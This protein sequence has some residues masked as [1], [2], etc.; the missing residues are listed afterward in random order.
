MSVNEKAPVFVVGCPRSGTTLLYDTLLSSG[1]FAVYPC[2]SDVF[3]RIAPAFGSFRSKSTRQKLMDV[4]L[5]SDYFGRT[6]LEPDVLRSR[7]L[8]D[9]RSAGDFLRITMESIARQQ[10][11]GRWADN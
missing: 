9:C 8:T 7:V 3:Y 10:G 2:E 1:K 4:W 5:A 11:V 6:G